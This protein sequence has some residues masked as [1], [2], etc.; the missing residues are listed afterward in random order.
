MDVDIVVSKQ[1]LSWPSGLNPLE[2]KQ[3]KNVSRPSALKQDATLEEK[4][5]EPEMTVAIPLTDTR[6]IGSDDDTSSTESSVTDK[7]PVIPSLIHLMCGDIDTCFEVCIYKFCY[8]EK[9]KKDDETSSESSEDS[10]SAILLP[11]VLNK[12]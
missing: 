2:S 5:D 10:G 7:P 8:P 9:W 12:D 3:H 11:K 1:E 4:T 6:M